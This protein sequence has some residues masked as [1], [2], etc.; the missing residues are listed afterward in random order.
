M[1]SVDFN[2]TGDLI[3]TG[4][5]DGT[6]NVISSLSGQIVR[7]VDHRVWVRSIC[8]GGCGHGQK[9]VTGSGKNIRIFELM[10]DGAF[11]LS[12]WRWLETLSQKPSEALTK[13]FITMCDASPSFPFRRAPGWLCGLTALHLAALFQK[14]DVVPAPIG[15]VGV[16]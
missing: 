14:P 4:C 1:C 15:P 13:S 12:P 3:A 2:E 11:D 7:V 16:L 5:S 6:L 8:F 10:P 9:V